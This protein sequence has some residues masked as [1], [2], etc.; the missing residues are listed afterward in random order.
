MKI[1]A[2]KYK[3]YPSGMFKWHISIDGKCPVDMYRNGNNEI[4]LTWCDADFD[5]C[6][7]KMYRGSTLKELQTLLKALSYTL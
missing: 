5:I 6:T 4:C 7:V 1:T 2:K 3:A